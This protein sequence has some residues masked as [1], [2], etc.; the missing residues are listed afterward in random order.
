[1]EQG[2][3]TK[4]QTPTGEIVTIA[5]GR[6][7]QYPEYVNV[8]VVWEAKG[9]KVMRTSENMFLIP[10]VTSAKNRGRR[11]LP[12]LGG[13]GKGGQGQCHFFKIYSWA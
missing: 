6:G 4:L 2:G 13:K 3:V 10:G 5:T 12:G 7:T 8:V 1:M 9:Y 11:P